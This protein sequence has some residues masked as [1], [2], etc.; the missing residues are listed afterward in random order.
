MS[1]YINYAEMQA[2]VQLDNSDDKKE[3]GQK[4]SSEKKLDIADIMVALK[5]KDAT[6]QL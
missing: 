1:K 5:Q 3:P 2:G 4:M 6:I